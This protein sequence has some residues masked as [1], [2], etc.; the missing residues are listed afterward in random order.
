MNKRFLEEMKN[1]L[2]AR[3]KDI[4]RQLSEVAQ[5]VNHGENGYETKFPD[6]GQS[7][8]EN[9]DEVSAFVDRLSLGENLED[10]L[11][12]VERALKKIRN[13]KYGICE[14]C[15]GE[16]SEERLRALPTARWCLKCKTKLSK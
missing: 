15:G 9:I 11:H 6:Y 8:D 12:E 4:E 10:S 13:N 16:I 3:K 5:K 14:S 2:E 1:V 7:E